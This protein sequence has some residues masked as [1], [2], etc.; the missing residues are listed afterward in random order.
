MNQPFL[1]WRSGQ[2]RTKGGK[3]GASALGAIGT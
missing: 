3:T 2:S 1:L